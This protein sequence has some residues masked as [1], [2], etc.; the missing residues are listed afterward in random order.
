MNHVLIAVT[1]G[2][3]LLLERLLRAERRRRLMARRLPPDQPLE[4][5]LSSSGRFR[6]VVYSHDT[7]VMR[8]EVFQRMG[9]EPTEPCWLRISGPSFVDREAL[10]DA[11]REALRAE[12]GPA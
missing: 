5:H 8:I 6:A 12:G 3:V 9:T 7:G 11:I 4:E 2:L 10:P 1:A